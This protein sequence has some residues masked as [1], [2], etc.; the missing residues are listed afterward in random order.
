MI[1]K[2]T[3]YCFYILILSAAAFA[4]ATDS[5]RVQAL[6]PFVVDSIRIIGNDQTE[7]FII[8]RELTF[9]KGD[10]L[11]REDIFYN[12]ERIYSLGLFAHVFVN[13]LIENSIN[14]L[15]IKVEERWYI[16]PI[17]FV[18]IKERDWKKIS[19]GI[20]L[21][22]DNFRG[23]NEQINAMASFGYDPSF[24]LN[25]YNPNII[26]NEEFFLRVGFIY[27]DV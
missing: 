25:Y 14:I 15:E 24:A 3:E 12:R 13:P 5:V 6:Y 4:Q 2:L 26:G 19:Y 11:S 9:S 8:T 10:T 23:R 1:K 20:F 22:I 21:R 17:P 18:S 16:Y 27:S 7:E